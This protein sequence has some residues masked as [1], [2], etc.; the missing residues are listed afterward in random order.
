MYTK[1]QLEIELLKQKNEF[2]HRDYNQMFML[3][4]KIETNQRL[5]FEIVG[6]G[7]TVLIVLIALGFKW[8][9]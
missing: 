5:I 2:Y 4:D 6:A 7:F 9:I 1:E 3:L 8:I